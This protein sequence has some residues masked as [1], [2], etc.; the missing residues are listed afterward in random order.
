LFRI[1]V[2]DAKSRYRLAELANMFLPSAEYA[3]EIDPEPDG[4]FDLRIQ[5]NRENVN[6]QKQE[7]YDFFSRETGKTLEWGILTG[8]RPVKLLAE[9]LQTSSMEAATAVLRNEYRVSEDKVALLLEVYRTQLTV[10]F[11]CAP[12]ATGIYV[13]IPFC[14]SRCLY[15]SFPSNVISSGRA[16]RYLKALYQEIDAVADLLKSRSWYGESIYIGGGTPT[17]LDTPAFRD[18]VQRVSGRFGSEQTREFTVE[19]GRPDTIDRDKL[20]AIAECGAKRIS[21]NPQTMSDVTLE[22]IGRSHSAQQIRE[23]FALAKDCGIPLIN[24][25]LI[26]GLPGEEPED[27]SRTLEQVLLLKPENITV[28]T[29]AVKRASRLIEEDQDYAYRQGSVTG[30]MLKTARAALRS[31]G[32]RPYYLYRQKHMAGNLENVGY[33]LPGTE[34]LYNIR[35]MAEDQSIIAMGA[36]AISKICYPEENRLERIANVTNYEIY[37]DRI[38]EMISRK[39]MGI[40]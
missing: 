22:R 21:I 13:G 36:G 4:S 24:A 6:I 20:K 16:E 35:I 18:L 11:D 1:A 14:P 34:S 26:A 39:E 31:A 17:S 32:Y 10:N 19:C 12:P 37:I 23:A 27:F 7:L 29:L 28:H 40:Q 9:M 2:P 38:D 33:A 30:E 3:V 15:C 5:E 25:D 8:V